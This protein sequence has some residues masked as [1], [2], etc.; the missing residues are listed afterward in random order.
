MTEDELENLLEV[1]LVDHVKLQAALKI[2]EKDIIEIRGRLA[3][4]KKR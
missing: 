1:R 3:Q 4:L 2:C